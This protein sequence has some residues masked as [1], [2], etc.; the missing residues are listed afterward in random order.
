MPG[1]RPARPRFVSPS[2]SAISSRATTQ[3]PPLAIRTD[4]L[5]LATKRSHSKLGMRDQSPPRP[6]PGRYQLQTVCC[7]S[8]SSRRRPSSISFVSSPSCTRRSSAISKKAW[9]SRSTARSI[10]TRCSS[11]SAPTAKCS[12]SLRSRVGRVR[13]ARQHLDP[14]RLQFHTSNLGWAIHHVTTQFRHQISRSCDAFG[15]DRRRYY[16]LTGLAE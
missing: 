3:R 12:S 8:S 14:D 2:P 16:G 5:K 11:R 4:C 7:R 15:R 9:P 6:H 13:A 1:G 10:R